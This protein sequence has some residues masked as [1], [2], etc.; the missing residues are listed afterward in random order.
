MVRV[1]VSGDLDIVSAR[2]L[3]DALRD[4]VREGDG[5]VVVDLTDAD[6][7]DS[8]SLAALLNTL[9]RLTRAGRRMAVVCPPGPALRIFEIT[10]LERDL[11]VVPTLAEAQRALAAAG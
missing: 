10:R 7:I 4:A 5:P 3:R 2:D 11:G 6:S 9:R 8:M 1:A